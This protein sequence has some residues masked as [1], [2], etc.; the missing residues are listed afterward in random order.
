M[1]VLISLLFK[2]IKF[3]IL[4]IWGGNP[5]EVGGYPNSQGQGTVARRETPLVN[6]EW[7]SPTPSAQ[8]VVAMVEEPSALQLTEE[9]TAWQGKVDTNAIINGVIFAEIVQPPRAYRPFIRRK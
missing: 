8:P 5:R 4:E 9:K 6:R 7:S 3:L 1:D 2:G